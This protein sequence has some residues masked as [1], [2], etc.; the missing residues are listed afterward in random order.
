MKCGFGI[1]YS[2]SWKYWHIW[3]SVLHLNQNSDFG[4]TL[5]TCSYTYVY[6]ILNIQQKVVKIWTLVHRTED[7]TFVWVFVRKKTEFLTAKHWLS[8]FPITQ[9]LGW[10]VLKK[11]NTE[12][13]EISNFHNYLPD[14][15]NYTKTFLPK[16]YN[17]RLNIA[18]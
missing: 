5:I 16:L 1:S 12:W 15:Q 3:V 11:V 14:V 2:I 18:G 10:A 4:R 8:W 13:L 6:I 7:Q 9:K 17:Q